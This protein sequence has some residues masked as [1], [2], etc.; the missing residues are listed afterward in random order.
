[1]T[2]LEEPIEPPARSPFRARLA[3]SP[4]GAFHHRDLAVFWICAAIS[5]SGSWMQSVAVPALLYEMT[6]KAT[7]VGAAAAA[8]VIPV[9]VLMPLAGPLADRVARRPFLTVTVIVQMTAAVALYALY[10]SGHATPWTILGLVCVSSSANAMQLPLWQTFMPLLVP[11]ERLADAVRLNSMQYTTARIIGP[12][13]AAVAIGLGSLGTAF[14]LNALSFVAVLAALALV[15]PREY[16]RTDPKQRLGMADGYRYVLHHRVIR[17]SDLLVLL[18]GMLGAAVQGQAASIA[19]NIFHRSSSATA[20]LAMAAGVGS[21]IGLGVAFGPGR[22]ARPSRIVTAAMGAFSLGSLLTASTHHYA[23]GLAGFVLNGIGQV[24]VS[25]LFNTLVQSHSLPAYRGR[26]VSAYLFGV[27][28]G[29]PVGALIMGRLGDAVGM[30]A[31]LL[32]DGVAMALLAVML[33]SSG[34]LVTLNSPP[35]L[36]R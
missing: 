35:D 6:H 3:A 16:P 33:V 9:L 12:T 32:A 26:A 21:I 24:N 34:I 2:A 31:V 10:E 14:L 4:L 17:T 29:L 22:Y 27:T 5:S 36:T 11:P 15:N 18:L 20:G 23:V 25:M 28:I 8:N 30:R 19:G 7:W 1:M 13:S